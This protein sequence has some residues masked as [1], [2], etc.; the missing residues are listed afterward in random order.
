MDATPILVPEPD[1]A[2]DAHT[3]SPPLCS[4]RHSNGVASESMVSTIPAMESERLIASL[5]AR[6]RRLILGLQDFER[7]AEVYRSAIA[8]IEAKLRALRPFVPPFS[9]RG[10]SQYLT[11]RDFSCGYYDAVREVEGETL[12]ADDVAIFVDAT[13]GDPCLRPGPAKVHQAPCRRN[14]AP[15]AATGWACLTPSSLPIAAEI[16]RRLAPH[17]QP[18]DAVDLLTVIDAAEVLAPGCFPGVADEIRPGDVVVMSEFAAAQAGEIGFCAIG[19]GAPDAEAILV[20]DPLHGEAGV[21]RVPRRT[22][23]GM[24][25]GAFGNPLADRRHGIRLGRENLCQRAAAA[26]SRI[27]TTTCRLPDRFSASRRSIRSIARFSGRIW[28][29]K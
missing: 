20:V 1:P 5:Y 10:G 18:D 23:V 19:A 11:P 26:G 16:D 17:R 6:R 9:S 15:D 14:A 13:E 21:Q 28:P 24:N 7:R 3:I 29:P 22:L 8:Q 2:E 4:T 25:R 12:T 27:A